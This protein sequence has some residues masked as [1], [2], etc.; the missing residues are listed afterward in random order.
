MKF[1]KNLTLLHQ[2]SFELEKS[3][4]YKT[5]VNYG[6]H[7]VAKFTNVYLHSTSTLNNYMQQQ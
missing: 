6:W 5:T 2:K 1:E 7:F 3:N 4:H